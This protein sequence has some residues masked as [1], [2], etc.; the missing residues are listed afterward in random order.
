MKNDLALKKE[1]LARLELARELDAAGLRISVQDGIVTLLG[2]L[3]SGEKRSAAERAVKLIPGVKG[4]VDR[5]QVADR[6]PD[7]PD[8][9]EVAE[10]VTAAIRWLTTIPAESI[11]VAV[12]DGWVSL[13]GTVAAPH[14][15][16]TLEEVIRASREVRGVENLVEVH[17]E[18]RS[19]Y[20][21]S[22]TA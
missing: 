9:V 17:G 20:E 13:R 14:H 19:L 11:E 5:I 22:L 15:R 6:E 7:L 18:A 8:D 12:R 3:E 2:E 21:V 4:L 16:Q 1:V 10:R